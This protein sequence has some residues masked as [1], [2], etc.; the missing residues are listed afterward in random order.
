[1]CQQRASRDRA[2]R[3]HQNPNDEERM[4]NRSSLRYEATR[5]YQNAAD[6]ERVRQ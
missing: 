4:I 3:N 2:T 5:D 1:M 6:A